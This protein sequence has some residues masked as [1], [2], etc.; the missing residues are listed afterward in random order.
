MKT[1]TSKQSRKI[2]EAIK[3]DEKIKNL[4]DAIN[5]LSKTEVPK[6]VWSCKKGFIRVHSNAYNETIKSLYQGIENR[7]EEIIKHIGAKTKL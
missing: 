7:K 6:Y 1:I 2:V 5:Y 3:N 4:I